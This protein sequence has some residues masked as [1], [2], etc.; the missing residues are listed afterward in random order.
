MSQVRQRRGQAGDFAV[1]R[2]W[3]RKWEH[4]EHFLWSDRVYLR[5]TALE[6]RGLSK[7]V[8]S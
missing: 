2:K 7:V 6:S 3:S 4:G 8:D 5:D 1:W